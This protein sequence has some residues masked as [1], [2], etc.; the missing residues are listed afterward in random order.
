MT[1][2]LPTEELKGKAKIAAFYKDLFSRVKEKLEVHRLIADDEAIF[3]E[4]TAR[5]TAI[6]DAPD[7]AVK[8]LKKGESGSS[9]FLAVYELKDGLIKNI[10]VTR[11]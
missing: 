1:L 3:A 8:A 9:E 10:Q 5:F 2:H 4:C 11:K 6:E 7:F